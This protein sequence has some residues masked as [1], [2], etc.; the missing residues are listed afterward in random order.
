MNTTSVRVVV[1]GTEW[2]GRG[3]GSIESA[4]EEIIREARTEIDLTAYSISSGADLIFEWLADA[5]DKG[6]KVRLIVNKWNEQS[7]SVTAKLTE[8]RKQHKHFQIFSFAKVDSDLHAKVVVADRKSAIVGSSNLSK[9][10]I[11]TNHEIAIYMKGAEAQEISNTL[12]RLFR[13]NAVVE[14]RG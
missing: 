4:W 6:I 9:N 8:L 7:S 11:I 13:S 3:I 10:G 14:I 1:T 2:L 12:N 5:L